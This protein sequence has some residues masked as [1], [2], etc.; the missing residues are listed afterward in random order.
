MPLAVLKLFSSREIQLLLRCKNECEEG[1]GLAIAVLH[2]TLVGKESMRF[3][4][5]LRDVFLTKG[6]FVRKQSSTFGLLHLGRMDLPQ[7]SLTNLY[8]R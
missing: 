3:A 2:C 6:D 8:V 5:H 1:S 7:Y 4:I